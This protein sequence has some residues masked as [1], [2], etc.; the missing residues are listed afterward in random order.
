MSTLSEHSAEHVAGTDG[1]VDSK[2]RGEHRA[3]FC[4][5][6]P[7]RRSAQGLRATAY[8]HGTLT[9]NDETLDLRRS[10]D[11]PPRPEEVVAVAAIA[12]H[13]RARTHPRL[14]TGIT[15]GTVHLYCL[16]MHLPAP[17]RLLYSTWRKFSHVLGMVMSTIIL[18]ILW[19]VGFGLYAVILKIVHLPLRR[20]VEPDSFWIDVKPD[21]AEN[22]RYPF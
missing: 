6:A 9:S 20:Q 18:T 13:H 16:L 3:I 14:R 1:A 8:D 2:Q 15:A 4:Q 5:G 22:M 17:L 7:D 11:V 10:L 21:P 19:I 12:A